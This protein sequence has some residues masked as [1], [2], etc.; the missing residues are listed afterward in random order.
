[1][2]L[3]KEF[4]NRP[5]LFRDQWILAIDLKEAQIRLREFHLSMGLSLEAAK[6]E[7]YNAVFNGFT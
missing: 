7:V 6:K 4:L 2:N 3:K 5:Y 1:L